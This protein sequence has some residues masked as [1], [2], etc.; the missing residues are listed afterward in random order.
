MNNLK[1]SNKLLMK[2]F[3]IIIAL[4]ILII[5]AEIGLRL[6]N[7]N[8]PEFIHI[9]DNSYCKYRAKPFMKEYD[10]ILNSYGYKDLEFT[11]RKKDVFR[12]LAIGDS[13]AYGV[14]P[15]KYTCFTLLEKKLNKKHKSFEIINMGL[16]CICPK[17]YVSI[18]INEGMELN[19]DLVIVTFFTGDDFL[20][21]KK[22]RNEI[23]AKLYLIPF[24]KQFLNIRPSYKGTLSY[25][26]NEYQDD[27]STLTEDRFLE[28]QRQR[29]QIYKKNNEQFIEI[30]NDAV[31]YLGLIKN[32]CE[33]KNIN[34]LVTIMPT[35]IQVDLNLQAYI[36]NAVN[37]VPENYN[38]YKPNKMLSRKLKDMNIKHLDLCGYFITATKK[39]SLYIPKD[40]H[41]NISGNNLAAG[42]IYDFIAKNHSSISGLLHE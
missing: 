34:M 8:K 4:M 7:Q 3:K 6:Y 26:L 41:W 10:F 40:T 14:V 30:L 31:Y 9:Y 22:A 13:F 28:L 32:L 2:L 16:P 23:Y 29:I 42:K 20:Q 35:E 25:N 36:I 18:L 21:S 33:A 38:F 24:L 11:K 5:S 1:T 19:P 27:K 39:R 37:D 17:D 15:Y 12:I